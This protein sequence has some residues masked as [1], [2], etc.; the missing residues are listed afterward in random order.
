MV[1]LNNIRFIIYIYI[2]QLIA[3]IGLVTVY[4]PLEFSFQSY[5]YKRPIT[6]QDNSNSSP[7]FDYISF[8]VS[9][10]CIIF[11]CQ[12]TITH[13]ICMALMEFI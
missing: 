1:Y 6:G 2:Y 11:E 13:Y 9:R 4:F 8:F 7:T 10:L 3:K 5:S 12:Y